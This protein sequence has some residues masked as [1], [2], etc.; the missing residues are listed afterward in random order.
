MILILSCWSKKDF[1]ISPFYDV[2]TILKWKFHIGHTDIFRTF[3]RRRI[4]RYCQRTHLN[5]LTINSLPLVVTLFLVNLSISPSLFFSF[6]SLFSILLFWAEVCDMLNDW[7]CLWL[8]K[9]EIKDL[10]LFVYSRLEFLGVLGA[11]ES[12][13]DCVWF[14]LKQRSL[15]E[16]LQWWQRWDFRSNFVNFSK[17][18][19]SKF[20]EGCL[21]LWRCLEV[22][23]LESENGRLEVTYLV[24][25]GRH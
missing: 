13:S 24:P 3:T 22:V 14:K 21:V 1:V 19:F 17:F 7:I 18:Y 25:E 11:C 5:L 20:L 15:K 16:L 6:S 12:V 10:C 2:F 8:S 9:C 4:Y 23:W